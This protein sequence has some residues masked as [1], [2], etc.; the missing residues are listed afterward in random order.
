MTISFWF[1]CIAQSATNAGIYVENCMS[2]SEWVDSIYLL[3]SDIKETLLRMS[4]CTS[5]ESITN[6]HF[7][8]G[9]V[10]NE[11]NSSQKILKVALNDETT[12]TPLSNVYKKF[13]RHMTK[14]LKNWKIRVAQKIH[15]FWNANDCLIYLEYHIK[16][17]FN[18][19]PINE[20]LSFLL[21]K[22]DYFED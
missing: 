14:L 20:S 4:N 6:L 15:K 21:G 7:L 5:S 9:N 18:M 13:N 16:K 22:S 10:E 19:I 8:A 17:C 11:I 3:F 1:N 2:L 12:N